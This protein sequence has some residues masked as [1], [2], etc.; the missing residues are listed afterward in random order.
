MKEQREPK[1]IVYLSVP[2]SL[3]GKVEALRHGDAAE[4]FAIDPAVPIPVELPPGETALNLEELSWEMI[5][6]GM[7]RVVQENPGG[8]DA[9]YYRA[10]VLAVKPDIFN[11]FTEAAILK[12]RNGDYEPALEITGALRALFPASP[13]VRLNRALILE[14]KAGALERAN[15]EEAAETACGLALEA[16]EEVLALTPPFPNGFFNAAFFFMK[17]R[18]FRRALECF[19]RYT[20]LTDDEETRDPEKRE[21]ALGLIREIQTRGLDDEHF[22][23]AYEAVH[24]GETQRGLEEIRLFLEQYPGVWNGWFVLG[25]GLRKLSRWEDAAASFEK[26]A[27]L[28]GGGGD[29]L[30]ELAICLMEMG[31]LAG[32]R[33]KLEA[34]LQEEPENVKIISNLGVLAAK[35]G[36][37]D[38]AA[39]FFR[40]VLELEPDDPVAAAYLKG[41]SQLP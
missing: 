25:W 5:L 15:R 41:S 38:E 24:R 22:R 27:E 8:E 23:N 10:F 16:Y 31:D 34:A 11:E 4:G 39:G 20:A 3:R 7:I 19:I 30:N 21:R 35:N 32:A 26:A 29:T 18:D 17:R 2:E 28:G 36:D 40:T 9:P 6:A 33:K 13:V 12:A 37:D 1:L 14:E